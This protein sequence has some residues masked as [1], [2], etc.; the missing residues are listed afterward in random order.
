MALHPEVLRHIAFGLGAHFC[1]GAPLARIEAY[2]AIG[3]ALWRFPNLT[4]VDDKPDWDL[5][6]RTSRMLRKLPVRF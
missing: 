3:T 2:I 6:K 5:S 1:V 4:L